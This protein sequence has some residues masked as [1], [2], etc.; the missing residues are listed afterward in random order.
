MTTHSPTTTPG[1]LG[2]HCEFYPS[3]GLCENGGTWD[4]LK[5]ICQP[6]FFGYQCQ[7]LLHSISIDIPE[8]INATVGVLLKVTYRNFT[9]DLENASSEA[10]QNFTK[11]FKERMDEVYKDLLGYGGVIIR[12]LLN[13]SIVVEHDVILQANY[14]LDF[15]DV[16]KN[17]TKIV[18]AKITDET[19]NPLEDIDKCQDTALCYNEEDTVVAEVA[20]LN[21]DPQ[22]QCVKNAAKDFAQFYYVDE[23]KEKLV[24]VTKC[25]AG[26]K[27][28]LNCN[29]GTCQ[30]D[31]SGPHCLCPTTNTHWYWG[32]TCQWS[33]SKSLVYGSVGAVAVILVVTV[34]ALSIFLGQFWRKLHS[35]QE[36]NLSQEWQ[37]EE[38]PGHFRKWQGEEVLK[39][40]QNT[41]I[42]EDKSLKDKFSLEST[43]SCFQPS[44][45]NVDPTTEVTQGLPLDGSSPHSEAEGD[46]N[47]SV[48]RTV[49]LDVEDETAA[50]KE[51]P[52]PSSPD[53]GWDLAQHLGLWEIPSQKEHSSQGWVLN[54]SLGRLAPSCAHNQSSWP[55]VG[56]A[57]QPHLCPISA[58]ASSPETENHDV[59][60]SGLLTGLNGIPWAPPSVGLSLPGGCSCPTALT[61]YPF[62]NILLSSRG[63]PHSTQDQWL[64]A[65]LTLSLLLAVSESYPTS[66]PEVVTGLPGIPEPAA[67]PLL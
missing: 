53:S 20:K 29:K 38:V 1:F 37:G 51:P 36:Y 2:D 41:G 18:K 24:C 42:W 9:K 4:G 67:V 26:T 59:Y 23:L 25:T 19:K 5:C 35:R 3:T 33:T 10:Y 40:F 28:Q 49:H 27:T 34:V 62:T 8:I 58:A 44:P 32:Q 54:L 63:L 7:S 14:T 43:Y 16:F 39:G 45:E 11:L 30:L 47:G 22:E 61:S 57:A 52:R 64:N 12:K 46:D 66:C 15:Q 21:F 56:W 48:N 65:S 60:L 31:K 17:L 50:S 6:G 13:G 55:A